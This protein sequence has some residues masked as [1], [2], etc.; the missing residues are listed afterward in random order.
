[1]KGA[2]L[3]Q[4][5]FVQ[6]AVQRFKAVEGPVAQ[7]YVEASVADG[8]RVLNAGLVAGPAYP[9]GLQ[10]DAVVIAKLHTDVVEVRLVAVG[11]G[12]EGFQVIGDD[13]ARQGTEEAQGLGD[14]VE[15][16]GRRLGRQCNSLRR[17]G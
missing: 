7:G 11:M 10:V 9:G 16:V 12:D 8:R 3:E 15:E 5:L 1:M 2:I 4:E 17:Y 6:S 14:A 13:D